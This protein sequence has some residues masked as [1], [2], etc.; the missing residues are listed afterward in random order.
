[1]REEPATDFIKLPLAF[2]EVTQ[3]GQNKNTWQN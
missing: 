2:V 3:A 1:L